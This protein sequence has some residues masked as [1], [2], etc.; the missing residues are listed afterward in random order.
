MSKRRS[1]TGQI[2]TSNINKIPK[3]NEGER[4]E[5]N[6]EQNKQCTETS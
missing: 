4:D 5:Q 1:E 3:E 6:R 2:Q